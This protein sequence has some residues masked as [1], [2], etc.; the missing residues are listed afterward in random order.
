MIRSALLASS[1]AALL[2]S[3]GLPSPV[4]AQ[5]PAL[6]DGGGLSVGAE[7][8]LGERVAR[9]L[10]RDPSYIDDPVL[11]DYIQSLW[12]PLLA[13][14]RQRGDLS[15]ELDQRYAWRLLLGR[16]RSVNAFALP[17]GWL[18]L[19]LGLISATASL[20]A[21]AM[22]EQIERAGT[23]I[24]DRLGRLIDLV[25][26]F[27]DDVLLEDNRVVIPALVRRVCR[28]VRPEAERQKVDFVLLGD[29]GELPPIYGS[30]KLLYR[31]FR[32]CLENAVRHGAPAGD[33]EAVVKA[34]AD[35]RTRTRG[36]GVAHDWS[37]SAA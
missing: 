30:E 33:D 34:P 4:H 36:D 28:D 37:S 25:N 10:Y 3:G 12:D 22:T 8:R 19:H 11:S 9:E 27:G 1:L 20:P 14:A 16:D 31:A 23:Q 15:P 21:G 24:N 32:E 7:R 18:G 5:L 2:A 29:E 17:G 13:A 26:V 35:D 6:G